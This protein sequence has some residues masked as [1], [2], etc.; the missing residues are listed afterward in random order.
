MLND[1]VMHCACDE[2]RLWPVLLPLPPPRPMMAV[3]RMLV[4]P[5][6]PRAALRMLALV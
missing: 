2:F 3:P 5:A 6:S 1:P 4:S